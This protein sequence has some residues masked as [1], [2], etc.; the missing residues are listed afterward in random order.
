MRINLGNKNLA[1][2][3]TKYENCN[4]KNFYE[5]IYLT[6]TAYEAYISLALQIHLYLFFQN[7]NLDDCL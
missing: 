2:L 4:L 5:K 7:L 1:D 3:Y 6:Y